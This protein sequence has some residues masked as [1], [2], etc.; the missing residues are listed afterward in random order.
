[1]GTPSIDEQLKDQSKPAILA[2]VYDLLGDLY[3]PGVVGAFQPTEPLPR[4]LD[5][6]IGW[7]VDDLWNPIV[8]PALRGAWIDTATGAWLR[9]LSALRYNRPARDASAATVTLTVENR[10]SFFGTKPAGTLRA[11]HATTGKTYSNSTAVTF[12]PWGG[13][14][15]YPVWDVVFVADEVGTASNAMPGTISATPVSAPS[16][17]F[18]HTNAAAALGQNEEREGSLKE[19]LRA[20]RAEATGT[21]SDYVGVALDPVGALTRAGLT[22]P[23][24]WQGVTPAISRV[25]VIPLGGAAVSVLLASDSGPAAGD[26]STPDS[27]VYRA[28]AAIQLISAKTGFTV[29]VRAATALAVNVGDVQVYIDRATPG[30]SVAEAKAWIAESLADFFATLPIGGRRTNVFLPQGWVFSDEVRAAAMCRLVDTPTGRR[31][32]QIPGVIRADVGFS[33]TAV[34]VDEVVVASYDIIP[35]LVTQ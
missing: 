4:T 12:T 15:A 21:R 32:Q 22:V 31:R 23:A 13:S 1:M 6:V 18:F 3:G 5:A 9:L 34:A 19:R 2:D 20:A 25:R 14:G 11:K 30:A 27:D 28:N 29:N 7:V 26:T 24:S 8:A 35:I 33:S 16:G 17:V 10:G